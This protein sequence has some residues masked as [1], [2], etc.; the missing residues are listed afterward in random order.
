MVKVIRLQTAKAL[1]WISQHT[2]KWVPRKITLKLLKLAAKIGYCFN[3]VS[4]ILDAYSL[5]RA[6]RRES[7]LYDR[8]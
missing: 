4:F 3:E 1:I 6:Y 2:Y 7:A 5:E 8:Y